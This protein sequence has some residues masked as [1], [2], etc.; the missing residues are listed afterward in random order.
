M[1]RRARALALGVGLVAAFATF[2]GLGLWQLQRLAWKESLIA[3]VQARVNAPAVDPPGPPQWPGVDRDTA[4]YLRVQVRG[5]YDHARE[6]LV[7]A[8]TPLGTGHWVLTPL[9][10]DAGWWLWVNRGFVPPQRRA[11]DERRSHE[12]TDDVQVTGLVRL[13]EPGGS[14]LQANDP[15]T[16]RW[17]SRD[18]AALG[19]AHGL[20]AASARVAP[21]FVDAFIEAPTQPAGASGSPVARVAGAQ[22]RPQGQAAQSP[23]RAWDEETRGGPAFPHE[24]PQAAQTPPPPEGV[25]SPSKAGSTQE[26]WPRP[27]LTVL[28]FTNTHLAYAMT[29]FALAGGAVVA[30][31]LLLRESRRPVEEEP[32]P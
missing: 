29:W 14:L 30:L 19:Q 8:S 24:R 25:E 26:R 13:S 3:R 22:E 7:R 4:E 20:A 28:H 21:Y 23:P 9:S 6:A 17:Y 10:T 31:A 15:A 12:P 32:A 18:V 27:G 11:R 5:R 1:R 16:S 2:V